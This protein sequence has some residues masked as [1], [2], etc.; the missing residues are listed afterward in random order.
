MSVVIGYKKGDV[1]YMATD[2]RTF[3]GD[4]KK[5]DLCECNFKIQKMSNGMLVG[6]SCE[7]KERQVLFGNAQ[8]IFTLDKNQKLTRKHIA[9]KIVPKIMQLLE[10]EDL[11]IKKEDD[12]PWVKATVLLAYQDVMYEICQDFS[13]LRYEDYQADGNIVAYYAQYVV[14]NIKP[15]DDVNEKLI[16]ALDVVA[17]NSQLVGRPYLLIDT[18]DQKYT[19]VEGEK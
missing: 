4:V 11:L 14:S 16:E 13:I 7:K 18:K 8:E 2:T 5:N 15:T 6:I 1:I 17:Q 9:T 3:V 12:L 19:L 10:Q